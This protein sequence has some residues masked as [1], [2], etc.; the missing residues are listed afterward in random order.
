MV[1]NSALPLIEANNDINGADCFLL[2]V[3]HRDR[4]DRKKFLNH[5]STAEADSG[6]CWVSK[7]QKYHTEN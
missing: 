5:I 7:D 2:F 3:K 6:M 4:E 1:E